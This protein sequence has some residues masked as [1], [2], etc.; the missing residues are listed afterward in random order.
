MTIAKYR[1]KA[2]YVSP[3]NTL[4]NEFFGRDMNSMFGLDEPRHALPSVNIIERDAEFKLEV[5][6]PGY[7]KE[8]LKVNVEDN[9]LTVSAEK[10]NEEQKDGDRFTRREFH[11][12][13]FTRSF[14][15]P[16]SADADRIK[17]EYTDG[18]L[19]LSIPKVEATKPKAKEIAVS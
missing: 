16:E 4:V 11:F 13:S 8:D 12:S 18:I 5:M 17:A 7:K 6:A 1:P 19:H 14:R 2:S 15:L 9:V 10:K 3:F